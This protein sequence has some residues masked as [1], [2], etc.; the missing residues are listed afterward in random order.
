MQYIS[1]FIWAVLFIGA[2]KCEGKQFRVSW[3]KKIDIGRT[4]HDHFI[5]ARK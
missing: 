1:L 5:S 3:K 2:T 4:G